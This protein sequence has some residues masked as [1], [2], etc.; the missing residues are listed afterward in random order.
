MSASATA[1]LRGIAGRRIALSP[2]EGWLTVALVLLGGLAVAWAIDDAAWV[3]GR[4]NLTDF[5]AETAVI[6][7]LAGFLLA[8]LIPN[9][10]LA[11]L[12]SAV[13]AAVVVPILVGGVLEPEAG[14]LI[15]R[16]QATAAAS[17]QAYLD[18]A[19]R[20]RNLTPEYGHF[21]LVL[22]LV[23]WATVYFATVAVFRHHRPGGAILAL[24]TVLLVNMAIT[25]R[26]QLVYLILLSLVAL[27][28]LVRLHAFGEQS[29]WIR[30]RLGD[31]APLATFYVQ[32]GTV[33][34][35]G[36]VLA[37]LFLTA[38]ASSAPL[39]SAWTGA[40]TWLVE[41]G[42]GLQRYFSFVQSVRGPTS[43]AFGPSAPITGKWVTDQ[44]TALTIRLP[45][46]ETRRY[47]WRGR[48][49]DRFEENG[50]TSTADVEVEIQPGQ[51]V[52]A[53]TNEAGQAAGDPSLEF[54]VT[55]VEYRGTTVF[56]PIAPASVD[57]ATRLTLLGPEGSFTSLDT[58]DRGQSYLATAV[59]PPLGDA[60]PRGLTE[61]RLRAAGTE[62]PVEITI[63][64]LSLP[65][66]ATGPEAL[67]LL[68]EVRSAVQEELGDAATPYDLA[69]ALE[70]RLRAPDFVYDTDV[71]DI[72]CGTMG[73]V[74]CF[75]TFRRGYCQ[76]YA[77]TMG[78]LLREAGIPTRL[79]Q[80]FLPGQ[81]TGDGTETVRWSDSHAWVEVFF[82]GHGWVAFDPTGGGVSRAEPIPE[83][84][85]VP[86]AAPTPAASRGDDE[87]DALRILPPSS[88]G[89]TPNSGGGLPGG[90]FAAIA[91]LLVAVI[92]ALVAFT[93]RRTAR[94]PLQPEATYYSIAN[95]AAR[96]GFRP[97]PSQTPYEY[98]AALGDALPMVR[99]DIQTVAHARVETVYG[100]RELDEGELRRL[101]EAI[102]R[103]RL[104]LPRLLLRRLRRR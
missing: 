12:M 100:R 54:R 98:A 75:A 97:R 17:V 29:T 16:F 66:G 79:V 33:F 51:A 28:L 20:G 69:R 91:I 104:A 46:G 5:L 86:S 3:L 41:A 70:R 92:L 81:R 59:V 34:V 50:W 84:Q 13:I 49:Y 6:A 61:N 89:V 14:S 73:T 93:Y 44:K 32:G 2:A 101:R 36:T 21:L 24:G 67:A 15:D 76:Y 103:V 48:T 30:R 96:L 65:D 45:A 94:M 83:G 63:R 71:S 1:R 55:P 18:L 42:R 53:G 72:D 40:E 25:P 74:E 35:A 4:D 56:A 8:K 58:V 7:V 26:D 90:P 47:Y 77:T 31:P 23:L 52:L 99:P 37:A 64:Y 38:V 19:W 85:P 43:V 95:A 27:F 68:D 60:D 11:H 88:G 57:V 62:Y 87:D 9:R 10:W 82:P 22:G 78:V 80:G 39:A 102:R